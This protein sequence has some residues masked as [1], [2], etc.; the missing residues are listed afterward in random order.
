MIESDASMA[1]SRSS[2]SSRPPR[3]IIAGIT[4]LTALALL[5]LTACGQTG[6]LYLPEPDE[7]RGGMTV[8]TVDST[9]AAASDSTVAVIDST[10][11]ATIDPID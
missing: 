7:E 2:P 8:A 9:V 1:P 3:A 11:A 4:V 10:V 5:A 6:P